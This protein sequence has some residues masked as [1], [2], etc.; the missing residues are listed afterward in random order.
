MRQQQKPRSQPKTLIGESQGKCRQH[1]GQRYAQ[2]PAH[3]GS[4]AYALHTGAE[5]ANGPEHIPGDHSSKAH[6]KNVDSQYRDA[7]ELKKQRLE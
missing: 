4:Y 3:K 5:I 2:G 6:S 1:G 7:A